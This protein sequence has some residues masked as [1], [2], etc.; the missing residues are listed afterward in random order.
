MVER[1]VISRT[2]GE[3]R[4]IAKDFVF[5]REMIPAAEPTFLREYR[6][7]AWEI[8]ERLPMPVTSDEPWRRTNI[9]GLHAGAFRLPGT[10]QATE[11]PDIPADLLQSVADNDYGGQV[12]LSP[13]GVQ[14]RLSP[15]LEAKGVVF[16]D[17]ASAE[18]NHAQIYERI[19]SQVVRPEEGKFAALAGALAQQG[20]LLYVPPGVHIEQPLHSLL[21]GPGLNMAYFPHCQHNPGYEI[22]SGSI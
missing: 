18:K 1:V 5:S 9:S 14:V 16:T 11:L 13:Q 6:E 12:L 2:R 7:H 3:Q 20:V 21:W 17:L 10:S 4:A 15:E 22:H 8:Y 19:L